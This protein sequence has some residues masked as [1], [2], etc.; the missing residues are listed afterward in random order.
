MRSIKTF[1]SLKNPVFRLY[2]GGLLGQMAAM[3]MEMVTRSL[4]TYRLTASA[5]ILGTLALAHAIPMTFLSLFGGALA[6]RLQKKYILIVGQL[7]TAVTSLAIAYA[8]TIDYLSVDRAGS[9]WILIAAS[10]VQGIVMGLMMPS[11]QALVAEIVP[12]EQ[13][14]N[15]VAL[16]TLGMNVLRFITPALAGFIIDAYSFEAVYYL[17]AGLYLMAVFFISFL[18]LTGIKNTQGQNIITD[19]KDSLRYV[20]N[21]RTISLVLLFTLLVV[22]LSRPYQF[23]LPIFTEDILEVGATGLGV[24][25]S[26]SGIGAMIGSVLLASLPNKRRGI[27]LSISGLILGI[28]LVSFSF[29]EMWFLSIAMMAFVGFG[30][31]GRVTL[32]NTLV[33]YYV[34]NDYRGRVMS[35][36]MMEFGIMSFGVF[37]T[38]LLAD[39]I[40]VQ[41]S[42][43]GLAISLV[44]I[45]LLV[46]AFAGRI[47]KLD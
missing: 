14:M 3:N 15:A 7:V 1:S 30:D 2:Y 4:L 44:V 24:L 10:A 8:L 26:V 9:W 29:S 39:A 47:R 35:L 20:W 34:K 46:L 40:G 17:T 6:D 23:L 19:I 38:G 11:R 21:D 33:Q 32:A 12:G 22:V 5:T 42:I 28:T 31:T 41:W 37:F 36:L 25:M 27:M 13:L 45:S 43:G 16:N 18:P